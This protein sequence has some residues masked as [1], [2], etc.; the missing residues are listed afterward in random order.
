MSRCSLQEF[1]RTPRLPELSL[2]PWTAAREAADPAKL[3]GFLLDDGLSP[4]S[5]SSTAHTTKEVPD[6]LVDGDSMPIDL[7]LQFEAGVRPG[8]TVQDDGQ[9]RK[10]TEQHRQM[11]DTH[12]RQ[13]MLC[14]RHPKTW[15]IKG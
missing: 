3:G 9:L 13:R 8:P 1:L 5:A 7:L 11:C 6:K 14:V 15:S 12:K 2:E 10:L 4:P